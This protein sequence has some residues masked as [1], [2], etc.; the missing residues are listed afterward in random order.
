[1][2][3]PPIFGLEARSWQ[4]RVAITLPDAIREEAFERSFLNTTV[5]PISEHF[6]TDFER[7]SRLSY[8]VHIVINDE[9]T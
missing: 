4:S 6:E 2:I 7:R 8:Q 5:A 9:A 1:M 3:F